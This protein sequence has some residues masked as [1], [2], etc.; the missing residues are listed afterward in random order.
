LVTTWQGVVGLQ[1]AIGIGLALLSIRLP[2]TLHP[3]DRRSVSP[4]SLAVAAKAV[5]SNRQTVGFTIAITA[6]FGIMTSYLGSS[7]VVI[8]EVF[9]QADLFPVIFGALACTLAVGSLLSA[10]LVMKVGLTA[11]VRVG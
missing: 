1:A 4:K 5:V 8:D 7:E 6:A 3:E 10:R 11:M 9:G 2:E